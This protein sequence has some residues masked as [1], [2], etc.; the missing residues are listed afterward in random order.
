MYRGL[1]DYL[2]CQGALTKKAGNKERSKS[3]STKIW[4]A[5]DSQSHQTTEGTSNARVTVAD[6]EAL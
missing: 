1:A 6:S 3:D 2:S 4:F 5:N